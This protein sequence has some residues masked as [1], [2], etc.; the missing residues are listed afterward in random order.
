[1][2]LDQE[3]A[4]WRQDWLAQEP[5]AGHFEIRRIVDRQRRRMA[6]SL[7]WRLL[8]TLI[9]L[10]FSVWWVWQRWTLEWIV[11]AAVIWMSTLVTTAFVIWN[12]AGTWT[13]LDQSTAGFVELARRRCL[14]V[15]REIRYGR[16]MVAV[17][18]AIVVPWLTWDFAIRFP[19]LKALL[20]GDGLAVGFAG[21]YLIGFAVWRRRKLKELEELDRFTNL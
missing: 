19:S 11:W 5:S 18:M 9:L 17:S 2:N 1:M 15:L 20:L 14:A 4:E 3:L 12:S 16:W 21:I 7:A 10:A 8:W 6:L 13:S